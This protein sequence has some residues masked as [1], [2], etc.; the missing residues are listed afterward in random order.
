MLAEKIHLENIEKAVEA[1][2]AVGANNSPMMAARAIH[3]NLLIRKVSGSQAKF[4]KTVYNDI[5]AEVAIS[6]D[7][8]FEKEGCVT[9]MLVMGTI[10]QH[11]EV[12]RI[13]DGNPE[14]KPIIDAISLMVEKAV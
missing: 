1:I 5:G 11:R 10:Y 4:V 14:I 7:A 12:K 13:L 8:Y 6:S 2:D 3:V 9:D